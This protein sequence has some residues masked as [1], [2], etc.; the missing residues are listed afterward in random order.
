ME[1][2]TVA[3]TVCNTQYNKDLLDLVPNI[4]NKKQTKTHVNKQKH[5]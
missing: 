3:L 4:Y 2:H 5:M 1:M